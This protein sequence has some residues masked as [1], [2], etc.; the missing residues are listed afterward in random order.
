M[1]PRCVLAPFFKWFGWLLS[2]SR[3]YLAQWMSLPV[4]PLFGV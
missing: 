2:G 1:V 3:D 4:T